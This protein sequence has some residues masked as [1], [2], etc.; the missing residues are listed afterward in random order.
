MTEWF[1][2]SAI[3]L[4]DLIRRR[5]VSS[6]E[7]MASFLARVEQVNPSVNAITAVLAERALAAA[8]EADRGEPVGPLHGV[9]LT[10]KEN[11]DLFGTP[12][13]DGVAA[14]ADLMPALDAPVVQRLVA[15]GAIPFAR[16]NLPELG[17]R[18]DTDNPLRGRTAN[19]WDH[20]RT[21]GG[22]SGGEGAALSSGMS[23]LG[24][25]N[26]IGGSLRNPS[27]CCG[28]V[29][30][31]PTM[32]RVPT[33]ASAGPPDGALCGQLMATEGA[34]GRRVADVRLATTLLNG[35]HPRDPFSVDVAFERPAPP[36]RTAAVVV[37]APGE[38]WSSA[39]AAGVRAAADALAAAGW[40]VEEM[41]LPELDRVNEIWMRIMSDDI[42]GLVAALGPLITPRLV[43][44]LMDHTTLYDLA[45]IPPMGVYPER[46]RLMRRWTE[47]FERHAVVVGPV[48]PEQAFVAGADMDQGIEMVA[49]TL[50]HVTPA[51]LLG[52]PAIAVPTG[53][54]DGL[55]VGVQ[56]QADRWHDAWCFEAGRDIEA[57]L[58]SFTPPI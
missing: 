51:A 54:V 31:R 52:L 53:V 5:E 47:M 41:E 9:P 42:P 18:L 23:V 49:R 20:T 25:G 36:R 32:G 33:A 2:R 56:V 11:I 13:T 4:A 16:T 21:P 19:P 1:E 8:E 27:F 30:F 46:A 12:T 17:L 3:E 22:S 38:R 7:V 15:A 39:V 45:G 26:D 55:P 58:G 10:V 28:V 43:E 44:V 35:A 57:A 40:E 48:W 24:L 6:R 37:P 34:M 14:F 50:R 29:G